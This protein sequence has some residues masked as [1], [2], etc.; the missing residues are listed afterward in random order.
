ML[1]IRNLRID[2]ASLGKE[3]LLVDIA[4]RYEY[5]EGRRTDNLTGYSYVVAL[6]AHDLEKISVRIDGHQL[7][8]KPE[9]FIEVTFT[10]LTISAYEKDGHVLFSVSASSI[11]P[12]KKS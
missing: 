3:M 7:L 5:R 8:E 11:A 2:P 12:V 1:N 4:P 6:P 9:G 10:G